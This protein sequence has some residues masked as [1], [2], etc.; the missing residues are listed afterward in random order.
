MDAVQQEPEPS[1][2]EVVITDT[3][4]LEI[5]DDVSVENKRNNHVYHHASY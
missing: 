4:Q 3:S 5:F 1:K 2:R